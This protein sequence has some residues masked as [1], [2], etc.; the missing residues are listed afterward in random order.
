MPPLG[1]I[2]GRTAKCPD[3]FTGRYVWEW[4]VRLPPHAS[5]RCA[6]IGLR[7]TCCSHVVGGDNT[8]VG[9]GFTVKITHKLVRREATSGNTGARVF[10]RR[11]RGTEANT[12][13][14][15]RSRTKCLD[16]VKICFFINFLFW[17]VR[18]DST[19]CIGCGSVFLF[20]RL[21]FRRWAIGFFRFNTLGFA[22]LNGA[23]TSFVFCTI[24]HTHLNAVTPV[25]THTISILPWYT[26]SKISLG[27]FGH[28]NHTQGRRLRSPSPTKGTAVKTADQER[29]KQSNRHVSRLQICSTRPAN[30]RRTRQG[31]DF[32][33]SLEVYQKRCTQKKTRSRCNNR[34][35]HCH[36]VQQ[37][38]N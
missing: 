1:R 32:V 4:A 12:A 9:R 2:G 30:L 25:D 38:Q 33:F 19:V 18:G 16:A 7:A 13:R 14:D 6:L 21:W 8:I 22:H 36:S 27:L 26:E 23:A 5:L 24:T 29:G 35:Y 15:N 28:Y 17:A 34:G 3:A 11:I 10:C 20:A 37:R 31:L